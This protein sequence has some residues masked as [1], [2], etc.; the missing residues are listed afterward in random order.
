M[1]RHHKHQSLEDWQKQRILELAK[2]GVTTTA[3]AERIG[4]SKDAVRL[5]LRRSKLA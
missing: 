2:L 5:V 4:V 3:I 1:E